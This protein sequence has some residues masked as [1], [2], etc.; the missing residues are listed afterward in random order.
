M[1]CP[2]AE[3]QETLPLRLLQVQGGRV[4]TPLNPVSSALTCLTPALAQMGP[5]ELH[6]FKI[7]V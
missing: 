1:K 3:Y 6:H 5:F 4:G 7:R 2:G